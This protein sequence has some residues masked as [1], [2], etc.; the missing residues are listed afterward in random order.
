MSEVKQILDGV[1]INGGSLPSNRS[2]FMME[3]GSVS[4]SHSTNKQMLNKASSKQVK[5]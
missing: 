5:F 2:S 3:G 4:G 1:G